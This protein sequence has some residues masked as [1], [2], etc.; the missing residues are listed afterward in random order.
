MLRLPNLAALLLLFGLSAAL[1]GPAPADAQMQSATRIAAVV[2][3]DII[4]TQDLR[5]RL[6]LA[7]LFSGLP[8]D[9]ETQRRIAPQVLRRQIDERLQ[10]QEAQRRGV[11]IQPQEVMGALR[12]TAAANNMTPDQLIEVLIDQGIDPGTFEQQIEAELAWLRLVQREFAER[13]VITDQQ[14]DL[15]LDAATDDGETEVLLSEI[16]LPI[17]DPADA[18]LVVAEARDLRAAIAEGG[19][20]AA[21]ARQVS[22]AGSRVDGGD[23]G[24]VPIDAVQASLQPI[25]AALE[26]GE[27]SEPVTTPA[28]V[29]LLYVRDRRTAGQTVPSDL[30][31]IAQ[32]LFPLGPDAPE[33]A[34]EAVLADAREATAEIAE[35][36]DVERVARQRSLPSSGDLGWLRS[37]DMP[38]EMARA[39]ATLPLTTLSG[40]IRSASGVHLV[41]VCADAASAGEEARRA[42]MRRGLENE[43]LERLAGRYLRDLRKEAFIDVRV[44]G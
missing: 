34:V 42:G 9:A 40:P 36:R 10:L 2:N 18:D 8:N 25:I 17:Y 32:L 35:C 16:L 41:M 37:A 5:D 22:A 20:F 31:Q 39:V 27:V 33:T 38:A 30:R 29:Q 21:I 28:G 12:N 23:L 44:G 43:A 7:L 11:D 4:S 13:I 6:R 19:E 14:I 3:D 15:A 26:P 24:W 1:V